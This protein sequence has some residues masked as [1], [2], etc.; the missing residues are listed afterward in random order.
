MLEDVFDDISMVVEC[1]NVQ[2]GAAVGALE[3]TDLTALNACGCLQFNDGQFW[4]DCTRLDEP[5]QYN[6]EA[7]CEM[8]RLISILFLFS[9]PALALA[10]KPYSATY[11]AKGSGIKARNEITLLPPDASGRI[12]Y[13]S[14]SNAR[15]VA[16]VVKGDPIVEYTAFEEFDGKFHPIEYHY[17]FNESGSKR[18][19]WITF[20][21]ENLVAKS[22]YKTEIVELDIESRH[23]DRMLESL[24]FRAD[25]MA[26]TVA[27]TYSY[28]ERNSLREAAYEK[29]GAESIK[30]KAGSFDTV[31]YRRRRVG[32]SRSAIIWFAPEFEYLPVRMQHFDGDKRTGTVNLERYTV[33]NS[34]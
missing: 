2:N 30:T 4:F 32:S 3:G 11:E 7:F 1:N 13:R 27:D 34:D 23:V 17:L 8:R 25:L 12:E 26:G 15:G 22:L 24:V 33:I 6:R 31:K 16:K 20:D 18:N 28:V 10:L 9:L 14:V 19:A 29:L 21:R 5:I